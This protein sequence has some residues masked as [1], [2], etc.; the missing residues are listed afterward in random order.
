MI[1]IRELNGV[2][3]EESRLSFLEGN[4]MF[5][6]VSLVFAVIPLE[7]DHSYIITTI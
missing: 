2:V 4:A 7:A 3:V 1:R 5:P 6:L